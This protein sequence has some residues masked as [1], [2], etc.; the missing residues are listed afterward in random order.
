M[1]IIDISLIT[2]H[3][4]LILYFSISLNSVPIS[5]FK[6]KNFSQKFF[7]NN[8]QALTCTKKKKNVEK[9]VSH[10]A[11]ALTERDKKFKTYLKMRISVLLIPFRIP[12]FLFKV[13]QQE[14]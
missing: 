14:Y 10:I 1:I 6:K 3:C 12:Q 13:V 11:Q 4:S 2:T 5:Q 9:K 7:K 8:Y